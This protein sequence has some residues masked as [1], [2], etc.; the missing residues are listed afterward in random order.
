MARRSWRQT[1]AGRFG[2][3]GTLVENRR[4][5]QP[6][7]TI[8]AIGQSGLGGLPLLVLMN[9]NSASSSELVAAALQQQGLA[10]VVGQNSSGIVNTAR[11]WS[12]D[13]GGLFITTER[14][15]AGQERAYLDRAGVAPDETGDAQPLGPRLGPRHPTRAGYRMA[16]QATPTE[17]RLPPITAL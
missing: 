1:S 13:G 10:R 16:A 11:T 7:A 15:Y 14:A 3:K 2:L 9:Q 6:G 8:D 12:V 5:D 17:R 4:R